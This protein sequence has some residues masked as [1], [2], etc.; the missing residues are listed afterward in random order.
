MFFCMLVWDGGLK[1]NCCFHLCFSDYIM[2]TGPTEVI[3]SPERGERVEECS[4]KQLFSKRIADLEAEIYF[5]QIRGLWWLVFQCY[6]GL[7][8]VKKNSV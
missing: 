5:L 1:C 7:C 4:G 8:S 6:F 2:A 3:Q